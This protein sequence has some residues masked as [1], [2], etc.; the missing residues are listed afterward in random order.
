MLHLL[1]ALASLLIGL[2]IC[3]Y[4]LYILLFGGVLWSFLAGGGPA[5]VLIGGIVLFYLYDD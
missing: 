5:M 2:L 4:C 3:G 1:R